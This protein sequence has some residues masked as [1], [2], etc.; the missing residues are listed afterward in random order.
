M[1]LGAGLL[2]RQGLHAHYEL[3]DPR[4]EQFTETYDCASRSHC[5][6]CLDKPEWRRQL[7][8]RFTMPAFGTCPFGETLRAAVARRVAVLVGRVE[9]GTVELADALVTAQRM[10]FDLQGAEYDVASTT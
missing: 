9:D 1:E 8:E 10:A 2:R 6:Y 7:S 3:K 5:D 4:M